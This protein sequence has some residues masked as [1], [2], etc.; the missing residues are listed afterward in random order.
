MPEAR[1]Q[2]QGTRSGVFTILVLI[3]VTA[4]LYLARDLLIPLVVAILLSFLLAPAVS[5]LERWRFGRVP[6]TAVVAILSFSFIAA[7]GWIAAQQAIS[8]AAKLPEYRENIGAKIRAL[9]QPG[10]GELAQAAEAIRELESEAA[11][12]SPPL[13]VMETPATPLAA[14]AAM[15]A[16]V[17]K[18]LGTALAVIVF[19]ILMLLKREDMRD[20]LIALIG[21]G[22]INVTTQALGDAAKRVSAYLF[23]QLV[24][25]AGF[26][27]PF[28]VALYFIGIPNAMLWGLLAILLRFIPYAGIW[29][30]VAMP[31]TLAFAISEG[32]SLA[33][34]T[35]GVFVVLEG[36]LVY[37]VEPWLYGRSTGLS[38]IAVI[39]AV[40]FWTWLWGPVGLLLAMP[41][42]V[43]IAVM[44]RYVPQL[45]FL[46]VLLGV[47]PVLEPE[48][49]FYQRL[50][51][52]DIEEAEDLAEAYANEH[53]LVALHEHM[54]I[55]ALGLA[56]QDRHKG[57][58]D[59]QRERFIFDT[60]RHIV[61]YVE[62]RRESKPEEAQPTNNVVHR[63]APPLCIV[64]ARDEADHVAGLAL[65]RVLAAPEF[66][67]RV[68]PVPL[69]AAEAIENIAEQACKVV[70]ISALPPRA[71]THA[72]YLCKRLKQRFPDLKIL[73]ALWT[74]EE[75]ERA[76]ARLR[77]AG[78]DQVATRLPDAVAKLRE[79][80]Q[81]KPQAASPQNQGKTTFRAAAEPRK[82]TKG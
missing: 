18:P 47:E 82:T 65:A 75:S 52:M 50:V 67:P 76:Q 1:F 40:L 17:A 34:W 57:S 42:T 26:G 7:L 22:R 27:I 23:M 4:V 24:V 36:L 33:A 70:C 39:A 48:A 6:A 11:P 10:T 51:A 68:L 46:N 63:P 77:E 59:E 81:Y 49:R 31:V 60:A 30:A 64:A 19:T 15:A 9:R 3:A 56:E 20:R 44:G 41:L 69:L 13:A 16:P 43:C 29:I 32:W 5:V 37:I 25:N 62:D 80:Q 71:S 38:A 12:S 61:E 35:V 21:S 14:L 2:G 78:A 58:L 8:V 55:P 53:G 54:V 74:L 72:A 45:G 28:G 79:L 73:V 66:T